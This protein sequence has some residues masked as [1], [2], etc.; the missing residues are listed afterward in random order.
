MKKTKKRNWY[1]VRLDYEQGNDGWSKC[2]AWHAAHI[3]D[4]DVVSKGMGMQSLVERIVGSKPAH[5][6]MVNLD[7]DGRL[8]I[9]HLLHEGWK[10]AADTSP[11]EKEFSPLISEDGKIIRIRIRTT[12]GLQD[13]QDM[14]RL[15]P[16]SLTS[17]RD[18]VTDGVRDWRISDDVCVAARMLSELN[19]EDLTR[20]TLSSNA[21]NNLLDMIGRHRFSQLFPKLTEQQNRDAAVALTGGFVY[22][23]KGYSGRHVGEGIS[24]DANSLYPSVAMVNKLPI[25]KPKRFEGEPAENGLLKIYTAVVDWD[26]KRGG[27]PV[28]ARRWRKHES[29]E[30]SSPTPI[31]VTMTDVDWQLF[32]ENYNVTVTE[33]RG[34]WEYFSR[35]G[36]L[37]PYMEKWGAIKMESTGGRRL[38][39]KYMVN[40]L[41]GKF[42]SHTERMSRIP[43]LHDDGKVTYELQPPRKTKGIYTPLTAFVNA[44]ARRELVK[45]IKANRTRVV[46]SDTDSMHLTGSEDP[47]GIKLDDSAFGAW[48]VEKRFSDAVHLREKSYLWT[49]KESGLLQCRVSGMPDNIAKTMTYESF[50]DGWKNWDDKTQ[51]IIPGLERWLPLV[52]AEKVMMFPGR[53]RIGG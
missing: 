44:Y 43:V 15:V 32:H 19:E 40:T 16:M 3:S 2:G 4:P 30:G 46:Y 34:G 28:L 42:G 8:L 51:K 18:M 10:V 41:I 17:L 27:F 5:W 36:I 24:V 49:D 52:D 38:L 25:G 48:K 7:I 9:G 21:Y 20:I 14:K 35:V 11:E 1:A 6:V 23:K 33:W 31:E 45:A 50:K 39:S 37:N 26:L 29:T 22:L 13:I 53:Y 12:R 47:K